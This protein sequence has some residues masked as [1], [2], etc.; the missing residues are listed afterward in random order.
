M[1]VASWWYEEN[2][3]S[4]FIVRPIDSVLD[5]VVWAHAGA[6]GLVVRDGAI[7]DRMDPQAAHAG[8]KDVGSAHEQPDRGNCMTEETC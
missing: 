1:K 7:S 4:A 3:L 5:L 8:L 2:L 6:E